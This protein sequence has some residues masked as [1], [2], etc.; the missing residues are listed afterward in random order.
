M[1][2]LA[3]DWVVFFH[4]LVAQVEGYKTVYLYPLDSYTMIVYTESP[5]AFPCSDRVR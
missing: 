5:G 2:W 1:M 3:S 4:L